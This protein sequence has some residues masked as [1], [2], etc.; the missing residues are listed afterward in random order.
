MPGLPQNLCFF[1]VKKSLRNLSGCKEGKDVRV[2]APQQRG[3]E[4][5]LEALSLG[6]G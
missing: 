5:G 2:W 1:S 6:L 4:P 3:K